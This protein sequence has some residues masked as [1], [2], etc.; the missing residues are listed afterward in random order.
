MAKKQI[1]AKRQKK[2]PQR[3]QKSNVPATPPLVPNQ[4]A[5]SH[6][7]GEV[8]IWSNP[9][10]ASTSNYTQPEAPPKE[11]VVVRV[12]MAPMP[13]E[14]ARAMVS[15]YVCVCVCACVCVNHNLGHTRTPMLTSS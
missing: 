15:V 14:E 11:E 2:S 12:K 9:T 10:E 4:V 6:P 5:M 7:R 13:F 3:S 8:I 1:T